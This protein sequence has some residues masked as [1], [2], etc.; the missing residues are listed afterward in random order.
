MEVQILK[1]KKDMEELKV[2]SKGPNIVGNN[3]VISN[4][5]NILNQQN[6][7]VIN[8]FGMKICL[9]FELR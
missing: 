1:L 4:Q 6:N 2:N 5:Q 8:N 9:T 7:V 3:N